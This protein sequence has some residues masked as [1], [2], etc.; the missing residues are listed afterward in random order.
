MAIGNKKDILTSAYNQLVNEV[1]PQTIS[2]PVR[3][4]HCFARIVLDWLFADVWYNHLNKK[5]PAYRQLSEPQLQ[6]AVE[7]MQLWLRQPQVLW[8]DNAASLRYRRKR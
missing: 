8:Q 6:A 1:L 4:N 2:Q 3:F 5:H 7:R